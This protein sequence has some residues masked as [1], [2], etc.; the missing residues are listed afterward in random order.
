MPNNDLVLLERLLAAAANNAPASLNDSELFEYF[1]AEQTLKD[2]DLSADELLAGITD[3]GGDGGIDGVYV[4][5]NE[6]LVEDDFDASSLPRGYALDLHILQAKTESGFGEDAIDKIIVSIPQLLSLA[7]AIDPALYSAKLIERINIFREILQNTAEKFPVVSVHLTYTCKGSTDNI[8]TRVTSKADTLKSVVEA[9][10]SGANA[11]FE[12]V[13]AKELKG[14]ASQ[15]PS[16]AL[17]LEFSS[18]YPVARQSSYIAFV[19]L[20]KYAE[21]LTDDTG[22]LRRLAF[23]SNVRDYQ[24]STRVNEAIKASLQSTYSD[25][26]PDFWWLNNGVTIL[27]TQ[28]SITGEKLNLQDAQIVNGLQTSVSIYEHFK[29]STPP[30]EDP[31]VMLIRVIKTDSEEIRNEIIRATNQQNSLPS[32]AMRATDP[33]QKDIETFFESNNYYYDRRKNFYK[34]QGKPTAKIVTVPYLAQAVLS[35][36]FSHPDAARARPSTPLVNDTTYEQLFNPRASLAGYLWMAK[37]QKAVDAHLR[38]SSEE[39]SFKSNLR[40]HL[41]M[42]VAENL[43]GQKV[44][45]PAQLDSHFQDEIDTSN[46]D[47]LTQEL[48]GYLETYAADHPDFTYDR[49]AKSSDFT[50]FVVAQRYP[51]A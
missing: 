15:S 38:A 22:K 50:D 9:T 8:H 7:T 27:C 28:S 1:S 21:F 37:L 19:H 23:E 6:H 45:N 3:G 17:A 39:Q 2:Y 29:G 25:D 36:G 34:N 30:A 26:D 40:F 47:T 24:G 11:T 42:V 20:H 31:R 44:Q 16:Q 35:I 33:W 46:F 49:I 32:F 4:F 13:G 10:L 43:A 51:S 48:K 14:L 12:F 5:A 18:I 41:S